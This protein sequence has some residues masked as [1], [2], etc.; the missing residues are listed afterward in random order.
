MS[1]QTS[2]N[3]TL[4]NDDGSVNF[5]SLS[6]ASSS[7]TGLFRTATGSLAFTVGNSQI[8]ELK[9][10]GTVSTSTPSY[11]SLVTSDDVLTSRSY[12]D[13][14]S[15]S[16]S[17]INSGVLSVQNGGTGLATLTSGNFLV[18]SGTN[19]VTTTKIVPVGT[20]VG[21]TDTQTLTNK[22]LVDTSTTLQNGSDNTKMLLFDISGF[23]TGVTR[24]I[25]FPNI[26][27]TLISRTSTD[28]LSNKTLTTPVIASIVNGG[29]LTLPSSSD[30][31][32]GRATTDT[33]TNK[34]LTLPTISSINNGGTL[35]L[36]TGA[37]TLVG[38]ATT[39]TLSN[40]T[41]TLPT[42]TS[43]VNTGIL[44]LPTGPDTLIG[45]AT[46]D[47]LT[48]KTLT[49]PI[50]ATI[51]NTG[52]LTLPTTTDTLVGRATTDTL[53][54]KTLTLPTISS[55]N[56]GGTLALPSGTDTLV[57]RASTDTLTNKSLDNT[58]CFHVDTTDGTKKIR[59][60]TSGAATTTVLILAAIQTVNR[61]LTLPDATDTLVGRNTTDTLTNKT[62]TAPIIT[63]I[64]N[65]GTLTLPTSTDTLVGR[66][67]TDT[68]T[69]KTLT[70][71]IIASISN[72]GVLTLPTSTDTL[73]GRA[74]TDTLTNKTLTLPIIASIVNTGTLTLPTSTDTL[75]GR[76]TTDSLTNKSLING[77]VFFVDGTDIT[78]KLGFQTSGATTLFALTLISNHTANRSLTFPD[79]TD[80]LVS[81][82]STD[83]L[84][85]KTLTLPIIAM[86][87]NTGV[88]TLPTSTDTLVGRATTD[89]LTNKTLTAPV[90][91]TIVNSGT[92]TLPTSTDTLVGRATTD[93]LSNK[94]LTLPTISSVNNGGTLTL[95]TGPDTLVARTS[96]DTLTNKTLTAPVIA[97][98]VNTGTLTLPT[99]TD[100]LVGRATTDT[101]TNKTLTLPVISSISNTG[102]LTLPIGPDTL[103]ARATTDTLSNKT[104]TL[105]IISSIVNTGTLTLPTSTDTLVGRATTDT[106]TNK[107]LT[108][109]VIASISNTGTLTLPT[110]TD[111]LIGRATTDTLSNKSLNASTCAIVDPTDTTKKINFSASAANTATILTIADQQTTSQT[112]SIPN[113][114]AA[115][116]LVTTNSNQTISG[117]KLFTAI[118]ALVS[119]GSSTYNTGTASQSGTTVTGV[120]TTFTL[121]MVGGLI[122]FANNVVTFIN[123]FINTTSLTAVQSQTV[124]AQNYTLYYAGL[125]TGG[126]GN[127]GVVNL[128]ISSLTASQ[129]VVTDANKNLT[130]VGYSATNVA[131][132]LVERDANANV[133]ANNSLVAYTTTATAAGTTTLTAAS[134]YY[135]YFTGTSTQ[136]VVL[137]V[138]STLTLGFQFNI[139]NN[140]TQSITVE[141]SGLNT[142]QTIPASSNASFLCILT[143][144]TTAASWS[145]ITSSNSG[146]VAGSTSQVQYNNS[147]AFA[148]AT[149]LTIASDNNTVFGDQTGAHPTVPSTG[150]KVYSKF[151]AG[152]RMLGQISTNNNEYSF[153]PAFFANKIA[154]WSAQGNSSSTIELI[155]FGNST[156]GSV[157]ARAV[158]SDNLFDSMRRMGFVS[159]GILGSSAGTRHNLAQYF[160][161]SNSTYGGFF[162]V[163]RFGIS[164][165]TTVTTQRTFV[166]LAAGT[167]VLSNADPSTNTNIIGFAND[168]ADTSFSFMHNGTGTTVK[169][170]LTGTFSPT[171]AGTMFEIRIYSPA[172]TA[173]VYYSI[174]ALGGGSFYEGNTTTNIPATGTLL[175]PQ[176]WTNNGSFGAVVAI[177]VVTQYIESDM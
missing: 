100:T 137:P 175:A 55:I 73:V 103:V 107:T 167:A 8:L 172:G 92:L 151:K 80:T 99:S 68:L 53:S 62:L 79:L 46:T 77:S 88:L 113:L 95:P 164:T 148:G 112:L 140:S 128:N 39:D 163:A 31:L 58:T 63:T 69:N 101:L 170:A 83:T 104:L 71:P 15:W 165:S 10:D 154:M 134:T 1:D 34:T 28:T 19:S 64:V 61:T 117:T 138:V 141:S 5:P 54:N 84:T 70:L 27:D 42:I 162:Y 153:Q 166:G 121:A 102:T 160:I 48:N 123:S 21:N 43:I 30:T 93:T 96:V 159:A 125:Q 98:I 41:L 86:I 17:S 40:K 115:D 176:I 110:S 33:L 82:T 3:Y 16:A 65:V 60:Q 37:D 132:N 51:V 120:G 76:A 108:L 126:S 23:T 127:L 116:T 158:A 7:T 44:T 87:S 72:T 97:T 24:T 90:I 130:S 18:G 13:N 49:A 106:L 50:I 145:V 52:T 36:P 119:N 32:V 6:F 131:S 4:L 29:T 169:D 2:S 22:T 143:T 133:F 171:T 161:S 12:V 111:T 75:I 45:R 9:T 168:S 122:I 156:S 78:K 129:A 59:F 155:N 118:G 109:P 67:T 66:A 114:S 150:C 173:I 94:T 157:T 85:N 105:P 139:V 81:R 135:Q 38:R 124:S 26:S 25:A 56:N 149:N 11:Q 20:V 147:G 47:T 177:D 57:A 91:A 144:G 89:T 35:T 174:E 152:R 142:V 14:K 74:T 146:G 136:T